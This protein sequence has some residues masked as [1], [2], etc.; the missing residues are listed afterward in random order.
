MNPYEPPKL[1]RKNTYYS[2]DWEAVGILSED[3]FVKT[4]IAVSVYWFLQFYL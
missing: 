2:T 4:A 1:P 3:T